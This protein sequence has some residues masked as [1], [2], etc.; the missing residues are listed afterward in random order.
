MLAALLV[1]SSCSRKP[2]DV[3]GQI[4]VVTAG[5]ENVKMGLIPVH[6]VS[7]EEFKKIA[8][9]LSRKIREDVAKE[10]QHDMDSDARTAFLRETL[11][12]EETIGLD[13]PELLALRKEAVGD[14]AEKLIKRLEEGGFTQDG[15]LTVKFSWP[16]CQLHRP[17]TTTRSS[18]E[19]RATRPGKS[20]AIPV[21]GSSDTAWPAAENEHHPG[22]RN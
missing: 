2:V 4:F 22:I 13:V 14:A 16:I 20:S 1:G 9:S 3:T 15:S 8:A 5:R 12:I 6:V 19:E 7:D 21:P 10:T 17:P 11:A 18:S